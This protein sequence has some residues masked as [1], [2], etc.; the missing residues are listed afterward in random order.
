M[1]SP[2]VPSYSL[3]TYPASSAI[4]EQ[5]IFVERFEVL[6]N[7]LK[8]PAGVHRHEHFELFWLRG[9]AVHVNDFERYALPADRPSFI[10]VSPGQMHFWEG[11]E[12][13]R[14]TLIS[15]S[16]SFFAGREPPPSTLPDHGFV[17]R[18]AYPPVLTA[19][20]RLVAETGPLIA[21]CE[22]EFAARE[23]RWAEIV[24]ASLH[25]L[26]AGVQRAFQRSAPVP[27]AA[28]KSRRILQRL[29]ARIETQFRTQASVAA[30]VC[31]LGISA[32]H[33]TDTVRELTGGTAGELI[34]ARVLLEARRLLF[35]SELSVSEIAYH[36][37]FEDPS[38]FAK[39][40]RKATGHAPAAFRAAFRENHPSA[41]E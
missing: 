2:Q 41:R 9:P 4:A 14:G 16:E 10:L 34:R 19:D 28:Q 37:G 15:F 32:G 18:T 1:K 40:F 17:H 27:P 36:L 24:R 13:I 31:D 5:G 33:L 8:R 26:L 23:E 35:H 25:I 6:E 7:Q 11:T 38:Y 21:R 39:A 29:Q 12:A 22:R 3:A 20:K 30:Y